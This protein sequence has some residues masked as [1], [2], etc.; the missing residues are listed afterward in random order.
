[1]YADSFFYNCIAFCVILNMDIS[2][3]KTKITTLS[4]SKLTEILSSG[5]WKTDHKLTKKLGYEA[6]FDDNG[7]FL[8]LVDMNSKVGYLFQSR[9]EFISRNKELEKKS[10]RPKL[11]YFGDF[12]K[13][14]FEKDWAF[15]INNVGPL[16]AE[17]F[18]N[19][20]MRARSFS[21]S[22]DTP[23]VRFLTLVYVVGEL[24]KSQKRDWEWGYKYKGRWLNGIILYK[25]DECLDLG[26]SLLDRAGKNPSLNLDNE[27]FGLLAK[28]NQ[29]YIHSLK[30]FNDKKS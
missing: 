7:R 25:D 10:G 13:K 28:I 19:F 18:D 2:M 16:V 26:N 27:K 24:I 23:S 1:M 12:D 4:G 15:V 5:S 21:K 14:K 30:E 20:F 29:Y 8:Y 11:A 6:Y 9:D 22:I 17:D 3:A